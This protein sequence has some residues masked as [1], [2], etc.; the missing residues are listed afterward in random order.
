[1]S[2]YNNDYKFPLLIEM[3]ECTAGEIIQAVGSCYICPAGKYSLV[4]GAEICLACPKDGVTSC[5]GKNELIISAEYWR[6]NTTT[7]L[8]E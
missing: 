5:P 3:I 7:D 4:K 8:I 2:M 6:R 1:M